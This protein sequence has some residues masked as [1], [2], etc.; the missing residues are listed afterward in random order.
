MKCFVDSHEWWC[1]AENV[2]PR[3]SLASPTFSLIPRVPLLS[4][5]FCVIGTTRSAPTPNLSTVQTL[6]PAL[7]PRCH[8][9]ASQR[10]AAIHHLSELHQASAQRVL[11]EKGNVSKVPADSEKGMCLLDSVE[12]PVLPLSPPRPEGCVNRLIIPYCQ[13]VTEMRLVAMLFGSSEGGSITLDIR[14]SHIYYFFQRRKHLSSRF[15]P[16]WVWFLLTIF[17][18]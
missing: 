11:H 17:P 8:G 1:Q 14:P 18:N 15:P 12:G 10:N 16:D 2:R 13:G 7:Q 4:A 3:A 6:C 5:I 9:P